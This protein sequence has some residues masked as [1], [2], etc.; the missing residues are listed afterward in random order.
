LFLSAH[1]EEI[2]QEIRFGHFPDGFV[3]FN[4]SAD[5]AN[6]DALATIGAGF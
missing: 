1:L 5:R 2:R 4:E 6:H 3:F